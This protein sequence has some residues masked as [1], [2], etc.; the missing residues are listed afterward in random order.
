MANYQPGGPP[1]GVPYNHNAP[2]VP[3]YQHNLPYNNI[4]PPPQFQQH[5]IPPFPPQMPPNPNQIPYGNAAA[6][7]NNTQY[8]QPG[9]PYHPPPPP[10]P[11]PQY[12]DYGSYN[13]AMMHGNNYAHTP[14][15]H[16]FHS[17][18]S[19]PPLVATP[20]ASTRQ[21]ASRRTP[22]LTA[23]PIEEK[24]QYEGAVNQN[25]S[26]PAIENKEDGANM[27]IPNSQDAKT[28]PWGEQPSNSRQ[29]SPFELGSEHSS[30]R[31]TSPMQLDSDDSVQ[32]RSEASSIYNPE[33]NS[34]VGMLFT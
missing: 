10:P 6:F 14:Q 16:N 30:H 32:S 11:P 21:T 18:P 4:V 29:E 19:V 28:A 17:T 1:Y 34:G 27:E 13:H 7:Q 31:Q 2:P 9:Y 12:F 33:D 24:G 3:P 25:D 8:P 15:G 22:V 5:R 26:V 20:H 23:V